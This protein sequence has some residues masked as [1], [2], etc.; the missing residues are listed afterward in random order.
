VLLQC[1]GVSVT[2]Q[3]VLIDSWQDGTAALE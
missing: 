1:V 2:Q 3:P